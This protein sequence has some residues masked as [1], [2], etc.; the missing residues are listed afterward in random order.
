MQI[1]TSQHTGML[2]S[3]LLASNKHQMKAVLLP[4]P[5]HTLGL[6]STYATLKQCTCCGQQVRLCPLMIRHEHDLC[7]WV[8]MLEL[9]L[10]V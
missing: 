8:R 2:P 5:G 4:V 9:Q 6:P 10:R 3:V 7:G 1:D